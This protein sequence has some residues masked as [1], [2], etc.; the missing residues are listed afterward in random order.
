M[1]S[2]GGLRARVSPRARP[3]V[4][5]R[6]RVGPA[7]RRHGS[8]PSRCAAAA[9]VRGL[10]LRQPVR[11][12]AST[13][14]HS[15]HGGCECRA[16]GRGSDDRRNRGQ[17]DSSPPWSGPDRER[18]VTAASGVRTSPFSF[19]RPV[20]IVRRTTERSSSWV[21]SSRSTSRCAPT[22]ALA[23]F[24]LPWGTME[25]AGTKFAPRQEVHYVTISGR[26]AVRAARTADA[27]N[28][29]RRGLARSGAGRGRR[30][31]GGGHSRARHSRALELVRKAGQAYSP[32]RAYPTA[33]RLAI[34]ILIPYVIRAP[35]YLI[36][37]YYISLLLFL[38]YHL[39]RFTYLW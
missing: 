33:I 9:G 13:Q 25:E 30:D 31:R 5:G 16:G 36:L 7:A 12:A 39:S 26:E 32:I 35:L 37:A 38:S 34:E 22:M 8:H 24:S 21:A 29:R 4:H 6:D 23:G 10:A 3:G 28:Q 27:A 1:G 18:R 15:S 17:R 14:L 2:R 20:R 19:T 11:R